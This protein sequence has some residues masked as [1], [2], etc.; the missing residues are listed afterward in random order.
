MSS[1]VQ[2]EEEDAGSAKY[3]AAARGFDGQ[4]DG[5]S[6]VA[7]FFMKMKIAHTDRQAL[8]ASVIVAAAALII[9]GFLLAYALAEPKIIEL[10]VK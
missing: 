6:S 3:A 8:V 9:A 4:K 2:F 7:R 5:S 1:G 10:K